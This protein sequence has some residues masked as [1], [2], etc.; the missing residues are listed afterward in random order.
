LYCFIIEN[1][2]D[3]PDS[4]RGT[5]IEATNWEEN[6]EYYQIDNA[7]GINLNNATFYIAQASNI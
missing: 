4:W 3:T 6:T 1:P 5:Y 7:G 2:E